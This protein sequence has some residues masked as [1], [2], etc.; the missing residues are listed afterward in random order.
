MVLQYYNCAVFM[1][2]DTVTKRYDGAANAVQLY[3]AHE[4]RK[5]TVN[6]FSR[7][8]RELFGL[9]RLSVIVVSRL[10]RETGHSIRHTGLDQGPSNTAALL[11]I[12]VVHEGNLYYRTARL[13]HLSLVS[14]RAFSLQLDLKHSPASI[15]LQCSYLATSTMSQEHDRFLPNSDHEGDE[16]EH[17]AA[18]DER[19]N[20]EYNDI[21]EARPES[22]RRAS[23]LQGSGPS[24][25]DAYSDNVSSIALADL[26]NHDTQGTSDADNEQSSASVHAG[27]AHIVINPTPG[28]RP[29][30]T[31]WWLEIAACIIVLSGLL[32]LFG[33]LYAY[34]NRPS[35]KWP[36]WMSLNTVV[37]IYATLIKTGVVLVL[38][39]GIG[40]LKWTWFAS[41]C[42]PLNDIQIWDDATRGPFGA[43]VL[44][45][46]L[47]G[48]DLLASLGAVLI[49]LVLAID[50]VAQ[51]LI[52]YYNCDVTVSGEAIIPRV[53][54][55]KQPQI[56]HTGALSQSIVPDVINALNGGIFRPTPNPTFRCT[57]GNC[58]WTSQY[59]TLAWC[60]TCEDVS[61]EVQVVNYT[62]FTNRTYEISQS[63]NFSSFIENGISANKSSDG[64]FWDYGAMGRS[65]GLESSHIDFLIGAS[66]GGA[67]NPST[68]KPYPECSDVN[69][70]DTW[71]CQ[72]I[73]AA[74]CSFSPC[75]KTFNAV[76]HNGLLQETLVDTTTNWG[77]DVWGADNFGGGS[78]LDATCLSSDELQSYQ[79]LGYTIDDDQ[80][81]LPYNDTNYS[82]FKNITT[83]STSATLHDCLYHWDLTFENSIQ[84]YL[85]TLLTGVISGYMP[86]GDAPK[87]NFQGPQV[88]QSIFNFGN[89]TFD[90]VRD[91]FNNI[92]VAL[93]NYMRL[94][95]VSNNTTPATGLCTETKICVNVRWP[96]IAYP[97]TLV[98][99][100]LVFFLSLLIGTRPT[101]TRPSIWKSSA[102][103]LL[104][105]GLDQQGQEG[106][107]SSDDQRHDTLDEVGQMKARAKS[108]SVILKISDEGLKQFVKQRKK[109]E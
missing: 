95:G 21:E 76:V 83:L 25:G 77:V 99:L 47:H 94:H 34:M 87:G 68:Q 82:G 105:H 41:R 27:E 71:P 107:S 79:N 40:Q 70:K 90:T 4:R 50:P 81:W 108:T 10:P 84:G 28:Y 100:T 73:G 80:K 19:V 43:A 55:F 52:H 91:N 62:V 75:V 61:H 16:Y 30:F 38:S 2:S 29:L 48:K 88:V 92:S 39:E 72:G 44:L 98:T 6:R 37:S 54:D 23:T 20:Q 78:M 65:P 103:A 17:E 63:W 22:E 9:V 56:I 36:K 93:T 14:D 33:T 42:R 11:C 8:P 67:L 106:F 1:R 18:D 13:C 24:V 57:T 96:W 102:L 51:Q 69:L 64:P 7:R 32:A 97:A 89:V 15:S 35:P 58:T 104:Y 59:S 46:T 74:R 109:T 5:L 12:T 101:A 53:R 86:Y 66:P 49:V 31:A 45:G 3:F 26:N 85:S 60:S